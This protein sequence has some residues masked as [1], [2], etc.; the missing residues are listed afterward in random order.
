MF[1]LLWC[2]SFAERQVFLPS[3]LTSSE[4]LQPSMREVAISAMKSHIV[5]HTEQVIQRLQLATALH[6]EW[7]AYA[8]LESTYIIPI[9]HRM[10]NFHG[11]EIFAIFVVGLIVQKYYLR[12]NQCYAVRVP[13][14][15]QRQRKCNLQ[16]ILLKH[17]NGASAK[18]FDHENFLFYGNLTAQCPLG[19]VWEQG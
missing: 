8:W 17:C 16:I 18:I 1:T 19:V 12:N 5:R 6:E 10:G 4:G 3:F 7:K 14:S 11:H 15:G 13:A 9:Y 2:S